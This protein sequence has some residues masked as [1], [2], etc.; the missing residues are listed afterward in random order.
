M[1]RLAAFNRKGKHAD[2]AYHFDV[3]TGRWRRMEETGRTVP[4]IPFNSAQ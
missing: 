1:E 3:S 4:G 2:L